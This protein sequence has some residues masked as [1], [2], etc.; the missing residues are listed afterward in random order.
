MIVHGLFGAYK[1]GTSIVCKE[2]RLISCDK[3]R[4]S[5]CFF[6][7]ITSENIEK[8]EITQK[9]G[10]GYVSFVP[11]YITKGCWDMDETGFCRGHPVTRKK[12][13]EDYCNGAEPPELAN[14]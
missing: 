5:Y 3:G 6:H 7:H 4:Y 13:I 2:V 9:T 14:F 11:K 10:K 1:M 8:I 12:F